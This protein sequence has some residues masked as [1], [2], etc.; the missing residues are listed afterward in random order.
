MES[1]QPMEADIM[2][3]LPNE[4]CVP[5]DW[6]LMM[7]SAAQKMLFLRILSHW[8]MST[9]SFPVHQKK[10]Y[11]MAVEELQKLRNIIVL[12]EQIRHHLRS[13]LPPHVADEWDR[14][15]TSSSCRDS[16]LAALL[17]VRPARFAISVLQ[18][19]QQAAKQ[20]L[21]NAEHKKVEDKAAQQAE[22]DNA[23]FAFFKGAL[24][25][26]HA[27]IEQAQLAP[28]LVK[29]KLH[30][31]Q[32]AHNAKQ[33]NVTKVSPDS[34]HVVGFCD[35]NV[36][37]ARQ[38]TKAES[39]AQGISLCNDMG[40][41]RQ[42]CSIILL[43]D[44]AKDSSLR[45]LWD[46]EKQIMETLF[47]QKQSVDVQFVDLFTR[48][49]RTENRSSMR[50]W[51]A[52][53]VV[54]HCDTKSDNV[55]LDSELAI[56]GRPVGKCESEKGAPCSILPRSNMLLLP[57]AA[58]PDSDLKLAERVRPSP[59][60]TSAQKGTARLE[61]LL[62][63]LFRHTKVQ[64][65]CLI[66]NLTGYVEELATSVLNLRMKG[67]MS[68][69][70]GNFN[71]TNLFYLSVHTLDS[72]MGCQYARTRVSRELLDAWLSRRIS[73]N[74]KKFSDEPVTLTDEDLSEL[75]QIPGAECV[76]SVD[77]LGL[78]VLVREGTKL[79]IHRDQ[80]RL[81]QSKENFQEE[82]EA[83]RKTHVETHEMMLAPIIQQSAS[84]V[85]SEA[86]VA[87]EDETGE[88]DPE[89]NEEEETGRPSAPEPVTFESLDKLLATDPLVAKT[90]SEISGVE[91]IKTTSGRLFLLSEK[92]KAIPRYGI[93]GGFGTGKYV[94]QDDEGEGLAVDWP[95]GDR[96]LVQVDH[97]SISAD[98]SHQEVMSLYKFLTHLER[99]K[100]L[101]EYKISYTDCARCGEGGSSSDGFNVCLKQPHKYKFLGS[102]EKVSSKSFFGQSMAAVEAS[103]TIGKVFRFR[104]ERV[105]SCIKIQK[106]YCMALKGMT[107]KAK[108]PLQ[109]A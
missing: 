106:P 40:V 69:D 99:V 21:I 109:V 15:V 19:E 7:T 92:T 35:Y 98:A 29:Q 55:W 93:L 82:F 101:T 72:K 77:S 71:W 8:D 12:Y 42:N 37:G 94:P 78:E 97:S 67:Q 91:M 68:G 44:N 85:S 27:K 1:S 103:N 18:S 2:T 87:H 75:K 100:R 36:P 66:V 102:A 45:G 58:S 50:R 65:P 70:G 47:A 14:D 53:R 63:S 96:T 31:K 84:G 62:D 23:Q 60:Q 73:F 64:E 105:N 10:R 4:P 52:G 74:G 38:S 57:E 76:R 13:R 43:P 32:V 26:D 48:D 28:R 20:E 30:A 89:P 81:W 46:E 107:L 59:E 6:S 51:A 83:L 49:A 88:D 33:A 108:Q 79:S 34:V 80:A 16:D 39:L 86:I 9:A 3:P 90:A 17:Q 61:L 5:V 104:F 54:I 24:S 25:R 95:A 56:C 41:Q 22:V 11:R